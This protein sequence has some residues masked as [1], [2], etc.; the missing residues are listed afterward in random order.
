MQQIVF[1]AITI[2]AII[3]DRNCVSLKFAEFLMEEGGE[4]TT[5]INW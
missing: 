3:A 2:T 4:G 1:D 5:F